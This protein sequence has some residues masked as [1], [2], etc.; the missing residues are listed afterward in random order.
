MTKVQT[1]RAPALRLT[2]NGETCR[3]SKIS[4]L[5]ALLNDIGIGSNPVAILI[6]DAVVNEKD[7]RRVRLKTGDNIEVLTFAGGG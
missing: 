5:E 2:V 3:R 6:N 4:T 7:R 1:K